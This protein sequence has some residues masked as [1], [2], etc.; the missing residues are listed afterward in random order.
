MG[1][2]LPLNTDIECM[3]WGMGSLVK[4]V[5]LEGEIMWTSRAAGQPVPDGAGLSSGPVHG[6]VWKEQITRA[7]GRWTHRWLVT[8]CCNGTS[9]SSR[10]LG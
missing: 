1:G 9:I 6:H 5:L 2:Q 8:I 3:T 7:T 4:D 10:L